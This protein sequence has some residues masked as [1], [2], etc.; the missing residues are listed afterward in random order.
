MVRII[1]VADP[2][3]TVKARD[4]IAADAF[5]VLDPAVV[6]AAA[7]AMLVRLL[8]LLVSVRPLKGAVFE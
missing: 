3:L 8:A 4:P 1:I 2:F 5:A 6:V 7:D